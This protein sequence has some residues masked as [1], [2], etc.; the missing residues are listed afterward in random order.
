M[1]YDA[2]NNGIVALMRGLKYQQSKYISVEDSP[3]EEMGNTFFLRRLSGNN[4]ERNCET[5][6]SQVFDDQ[7]WEL[8]IG[9]QKSNHNQ[10]INF[11]EINRKVD[12][13]IKT[14]DNPA[15]WESYGARVQKYLNWKIEDK[16]NFYLM[17]MQ[18]KVVDTVIY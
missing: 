17:I 3:S 2:I 7:I 15:N 18:I 8:N 1:G 9:F 10:A 16:K 5:L 13:I 6:S 11:D 4:D 14:I 12:C